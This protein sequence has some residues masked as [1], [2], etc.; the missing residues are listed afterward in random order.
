MIGYQCISLFTAEN[1]KYIIILL[2]LQAVIVLFAVALVIKIFIPYPIMN[3]NL[4]PYFY[5]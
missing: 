1:K 2:L 4:M 3:L 5:K